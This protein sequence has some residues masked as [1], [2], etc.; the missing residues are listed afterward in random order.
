MS[1]FFNVDNPVWKFVGRIADFFLL[2]VLWLVCSLPVITIGSSTTALFYVTLKMAED[3]EGKIG[4][5]FFKSFKM[6]FK[7]GTIL[8]AGFLAFGIVIIIDYIW[9][10]QDGS[11]AA[12]AMIITLVVVSILYLMVLSMIFVM[13]A[14]CNNNTYSLFKMTCAIVIRNFLPVLAGVIIIVAFIL[15]G[16]FV[17]WP[18]LV[19]TPGMAAYLNSLLY[20]QILNRYN[21][22]ID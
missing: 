17:F 20:K 22:T 21:L 9:A 19:I 3:K 8:W 15:V 5:D 13:L 18:L 7:Q 2:S 4:S 16:V 10:F 14:R 11:V 12:S 6:N 1:K